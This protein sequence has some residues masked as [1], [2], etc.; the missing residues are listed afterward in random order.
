MFNL[1]NQE[2]LNKLNLYSGDQVFVFSKDDINYVQSKE[3]HS[4]LK[5]KLYPNKEPSQGVSLA[6]MQ[7]ENNANEC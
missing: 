1:A 5:N 7:T 6:N 3:I 4:F 2:E